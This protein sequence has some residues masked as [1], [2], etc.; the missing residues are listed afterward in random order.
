M[1]LLDCV[2][3]YLQCLRKVQQYVGVQHEGQV[4]RFG[5]YDGRGAEYWASIYIA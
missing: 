2:A 4:I 3:G 5:V 1:N